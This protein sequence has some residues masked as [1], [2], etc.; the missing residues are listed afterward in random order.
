MSETIF[1]RI[2]IILK[3][4]RKILE[5]IFKVKFEAELS[6]RQTDK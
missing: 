1:K 3:N 6:W 5:H 4:D 2:Y